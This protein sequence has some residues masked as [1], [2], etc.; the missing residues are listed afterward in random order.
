[1]RAPMTINRNIFG[2]TASTYLSYKSKY[3][4]YDALYSLTFFLFLPLSLYLS[5]I[6]CKIKYAHLLSE[7]LKK[8]KLKYW[9]DLTIYHQV[10]GF[11]SFG[12]NLIGYYHNLLLFLYLFRPH[13]SLEHL[14][15]I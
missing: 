2:K 4:L 14:A 6:I 11:K 10:N 15:F 7:T 13:H 3:N 12:I 8:G 1:M 9:Y 5:H